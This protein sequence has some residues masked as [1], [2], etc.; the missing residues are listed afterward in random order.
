MNENALNGILQVAAEEIEQTLRDP[1]EKFLLL[2]FD[3]T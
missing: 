3:G 1:F 2:E